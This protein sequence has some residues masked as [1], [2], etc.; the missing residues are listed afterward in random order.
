MHAGECATSDVHLGAGCW[1]ASWSYLEMKT[2]NVTRLWKM[3]FSTGFW[4]VHCFRMSSFSLMVGTSLENGLIVRSFAVLWPVLT[5][6]EP[7]WY[8]FR[9]KPIGKFNSAETWS[10]FSHH[11]SVNVRY[12]HLVTLILRYYSDFRSNPSGSSCRSVSLL[13]TFTYRSSFIWL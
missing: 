8:L 9:S 13:K 1:I 10:D 2:K 3:D 11:L 4:L 7:I 12:L 6:L 5:N